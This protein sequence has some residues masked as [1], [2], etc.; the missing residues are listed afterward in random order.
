MVDSLGKT[1]PKTTKKDAATVATTQKLTS[2]KG[3]YMEDRNHGEVVLAANIGKQS[4]ASEKETS[5]W[6]SIKSFEQNTQISEHYAKR[7]PN[8]P[9]ASGM[10]NAFDGGKAASTAYSVQFFANQTLVL[11]SGD[12]KQK[13]FKKVTSGKKRGKDL[14]AERVEEFSFA[15][16][17]EVLVPEEEVVKDKTKRTEK[18]SEALRMK[19]WEI[20]GTVSSPNKQFSNTQAPE[21][22]ANN[23]PLEQ[24]IDKNGKHVVKHKQYSD[25]IES[26][27]ESH[28]NTIRKPVTRSLIRKRAPAKEQLHKIKNVPS[29]S[30]K[31]NPLEKNILSFEEGGSGR[32][33]GAVNGGSSIYKGNERES[34]QTEPHQICFAERD[35]ADDIQQATDA[36][37]ATTPAEKISSLGNKIGGFHSCPPEKNSEFVEPGLGIQRNDSPRS[38]VMKMANQLGDINS[39][40][41]PGHGDQ[42]EDFANPSLKNI[43]DPQSDL[44]S[45]T[46]EMRTTIKSSSPGSLP[47]SNQ[48]ELGNCSPVERV[49]NIEKICS[50]KSLLTS[51]PDCYKPNMETE[52][53]DDERE[54]EDSPVMQSVLIVEEKD[55]ENRLSISS[56]EETDSEGSEEGSPINEDRRETESLTTEIISS[57]GE[58]SNR[59]QVPSEQNQEDG[60]TSAII[61]F[62]LALERLKSKMMSVTSNK[63][64]EILMSVAEGIHLQLQNAESQI[65]TDVG[66]LTSLRLPLQPVPSITYAYYPFVHEQQEQ[67]KLIHEKFKEE[68]RQ[69]IQD[70]RS[71]LE[72]LEAHQTEFKGTVEKQKA[73][74]RKLLLQAEEV[75]EIQLNDAQRRIAAVHKLARK[76]M[77]Q[78][79]NVIAECLKEGILS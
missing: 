77:L 49:F 34:S 69:Y 33:H 37:K 15:T 62:S 42:Q 30:C 59:F 11:Q 26:D 45:P 1:R 79:K 61:H 4:E 41:L 78:V 21:V 72:G 36:S 32:L 39:P 9:A 10:H 28:D 2:R 75:T 64:A 48:K 3:N 29:L 46:F 20:L 16:A 53:S 60:L 63:S 40:T 27:A 57:K 44:Q 18:S 50:F 70:C 76:K 51:K 38:P 71:T 19:L 35:N 56:S 8:L 43:M 22:G 65:Q 66:K 54:L 13:K 24:K 55:F 68:V 74:H 6:V 12:G 17:Q 52:S 5:P 73:S 25:T 7:T 58:E 31:Q 14:A 47:N 67:L 23:L